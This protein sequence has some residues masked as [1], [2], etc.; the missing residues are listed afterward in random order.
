MM[1]SAI[2]VIPATLGKLL[3]PKRSLKW[4]QFCTALTVQAVAQGY[5]LGSIRW[6]IAQAALESSWGESSLATSTNN[7][8]GMH[9]PSKRRTVNAGAVESF[10]GIANVQYL[11]YATP[12][13]CARDRILWDREFN[14]SIWPLRSSG[15]G[16]SVAVAHRYNGSP[17][18]WGA[19]ANVERIHKK[20]IGK[21]MTV[22]LVVLPLE[23]YII[24]RI[25]G[26]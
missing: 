25:I 22:P 11:K 20:E 21:A 24:T 17:A 10:D 2:T 16:Y 18:Y 26:Q 5:S 4:L 7:F 3:T 13:Q 14:E 6:M 1:A 15:E 8:T 12:W 23:L 19:V 9:K